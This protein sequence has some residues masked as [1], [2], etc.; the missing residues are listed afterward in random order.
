M[1]DSGCN[2]RKQE[3]VGEKGC[4]NWEPFNGKWQK[5]NEN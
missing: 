2:M 4:I 3:G 1:K 5:L